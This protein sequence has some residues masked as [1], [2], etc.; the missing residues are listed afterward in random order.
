MEYFSINADIQRLFSVEPK[1][2]VKV[3]LKWKVIQSE[4]QAFNLSNASPNPN[5]NLHPQFFSLLIWD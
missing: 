1:T 5:F 4:I 2:S 3:S